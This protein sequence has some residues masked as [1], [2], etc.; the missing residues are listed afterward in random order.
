MKNKKLLSVVVFLSPLLMMAAEQNAKSIIN[1][2]L[3]DW[4]LPVFFLFIIGGAIHGIISNSALIADKNEE[5]T[6]WKGFAGVAKIILF[7]LLAF[8]IIAGIAAAAN[9]AIAAIKIQ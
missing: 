9:A 7:Y 4:L 5:G 6:V 3:D 2:F 1:K 8:A